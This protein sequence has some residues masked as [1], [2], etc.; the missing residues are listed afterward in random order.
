MLYIGFS[1]TDLLISKVIR[2]VTKSPTSHAFFLFDCNG[3]EMVFEASL[4]GTRLVPWKIFQNTEKVIKITKLPYSSQEV[5]TPLLEDLSS[6]Y[7]FGGLIG[8]SFVVIGR[9]FRKKWTN[10][11]NDPHR[12][13]CSEIVAKRLKD[14]GDP[15]LQDCNPSCMTPKDLYDIF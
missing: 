11:W 9:W 4:F 1:T 3:V 7:D 5:M 12:S 2:W 14:I 6:P 13:F 15:N 8:S 10:P